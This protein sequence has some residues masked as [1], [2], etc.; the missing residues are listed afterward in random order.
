MRATSMSRDNLEVVNLRR[1]RDE[2]RNDYSRNYG[3]IFITT[4][5]SLI[6]ITDFRENIILDLNNNYH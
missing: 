3:N 6:N 4:H 5:L 1:Q 2:L